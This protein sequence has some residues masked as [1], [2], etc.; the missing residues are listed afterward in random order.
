P[1]D[2]RGQEGPDDQGLR[3]SC[4]GNGPQA[5]NCSG[6]LLSHRSAARRWKAKGERPTARKTGPSDGRRL[7]SVTE[8]QVSCDSRH[9]GARGCDRRASARDLAPQGRIEIGGPNPKGSARVTSFSSA[10][11]RRVVGMTNRGSDE[12]ARIGGAI[13][14]SES[15]T[16]VRS[17]ERPRVR[18]L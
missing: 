7:T 15:H 1:P 13:T 6:H 10:I 17:G 12:R 14:E 4:K 3:G 9:P 8:T 16:R 11:A 2:R 5:W 18:S